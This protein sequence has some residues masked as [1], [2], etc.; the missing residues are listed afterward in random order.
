MTCLDSTW[1]EARIASVKA[2]IEA[3][4]AAMDS[5]VAGEVQEYT[6]D[7]GQTRQRVTKQNLASLQ[8]AIDTLYA[9]LDALCARRYGGGTIAI[10]SW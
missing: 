10:P 5:I 1:L 8:A 6:L 2:S 7:T 9:R 3:Y 4:E